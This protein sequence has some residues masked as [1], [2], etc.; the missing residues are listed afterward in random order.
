MNKDYDLKFTEVS[1]EEEALLIVQSEP[2]IVASFP[3]NLLTDNVLFEALRRDH[4]VYGMINRIFFSD[5]L[6]NRL[7]LDNPQR[8]FENLNLSLIKPKHLLN[9]LKVEGLAIQF[10]PESML[11]TELCTIAIEQNVEAHEYVPLQLRDASYINKLI[12]Q[13][14]EYVRRIDIEQR[15]S[16]ILKQVVLDH[17]FVI[18]FMVMPDRTPEIC[19]AIMQHDPK[20]IAYF[21]EPVYDKPAMLEKMSQLE[22]FSNPNDKEV[23]DSEIVRKSLAEYLFTKNPE[24]YHRLPLASKTWDMA[25]AAVEYNPDNILNTPTSLKRSGKLWEIAL[26]QKPEFYKTIPLDQQSDSIRIFIAREKARKNNTSLV[27]SLSESAN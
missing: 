22:Y 21:P 4:R 8:V 17:P 27:S 15:D 26:K 25:V 3:E 20:W 16:G 19:E 6:V 24:Y 11:T 13:A 2:T 14:P 1:S 9:L 18:E 12:L 10:I 7:I 23:F 5:D